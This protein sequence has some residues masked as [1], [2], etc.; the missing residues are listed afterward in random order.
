MSSSH[1]CTASQG[2]INIIYLYLRKIV[3]V[4][5]AQELGIKDY[6]RVYPQDFR[7]GSVLSSLLNKLVG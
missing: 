6:P 7:G 2:P 4:V 5:V 1:V 3:V